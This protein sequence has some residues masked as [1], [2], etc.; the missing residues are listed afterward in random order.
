MA[1]D[2]RYVISDVQC[3]IFVLKLPCYPFRVDIQPLRLWK[4]RRPALPR[5]R[6]EIIIEKLKAELTKPWKGDIMRFTIG[7]QEIDC[8]NSLEKEGLE[9]MFVFRLC[10]PV[11][12]DLFNIYQ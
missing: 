2:V 4:S 10:A 6:D 5:G 9:I 11:G 3:M 1:D 8:T 7:N 12:L